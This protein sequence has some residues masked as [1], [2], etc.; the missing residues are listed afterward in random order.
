[1]SKAERNGFCRSHH[2]LGVLSHIFLQFSPGI[3]LPHGMPLFPLSTPS[4]TQ[5]N[6]TKSVVSLKHPQFPEDALGRREHKTH[7]KLRAVAKQIITEP[8]GKQTQRRQMN[9]ACSL[10]PVRQNLI[11]SCFYFPSTQD[12][13]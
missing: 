10:L 6:L 9:S 1:M 5:G 2:A 4:G 13:S 7:G 12:P 8:V 11:P 3:R